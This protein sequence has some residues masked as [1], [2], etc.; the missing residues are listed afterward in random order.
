MLAFTFEN[1]RF[2][3]REIDFLPSVLHPLPSKM[4]Q[5]E[6]TSPR[7]STRVQNLFRY[8]PSETYFARLK[9]AGKSIRKSLKTTVF[10]V[11]QLRLADSVKESR[12][13]EVSRRSFGNGKMCFG[14]ALQIYLDK[15]ELNPDLKPVTEF[16]I[17]GRPFPRWMFANDSTDGKQFSE[18]FRN[19]TQSMRTAISGEIVAFDGKTIHSSAG[20]GKHPRWFQPVVRRQVISNAFVSRSS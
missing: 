4:S 11:A 10:S 20:R 1:L 6:T 5:Q 7:E 2:R 19:W 17:R 13:V 18:C 9:V 16:I 8:R 12:K 3:K 14:D 15:L